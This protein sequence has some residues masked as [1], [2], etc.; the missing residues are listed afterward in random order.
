MYGI[1]NKSGALMVPRRTLLQM[2]AA[3]AAGIWVGHLPP[4]VRGARTGGQSVVVLGGGLSGL[5]AAYEL[6]R[7]GNEVIVLE[8]QQR[9]GGRIYSS[10]EGLLQGQIAEYGATRIPNVHDL[11]L[12]YAHEFGLTLN[13]FPPSRTN[14]LV[15]G[16]AFLQP[17]DGEPWPLNLSPQEQ[18][19]G[20]DY[21]AA[22]LSETSPA[23]RHADALGW[24]PANLA[25]Q[26]DPL[27]MVS[28][29][30]NIGAGRDMINLYMAA[31]GSRSRVC[32]ALIVGAQD[33]LL[34]N[35]TSFAHI[36]GG[37]EN[38]P[39]AIAAALGPAVH[40][41]T[42]VTGIERHAQFM[43][44]YARNESGPLSFQADHVISALPPTILR[45]IPI[46]P[47]LPALCAGDRPV[48]PERGL[49][50]RHPDAEP[51]LERDGHERAQH[52]GD[53]Y[54]RRARLGYQQRPA[55]LVRFAQSLHRRSRVGVRR[56]HG[57]PAQADGRRL[58]RA[59][60][61]SVARP[62][63]SPLLERISLEG[64]ALGARR[65]LGHLA[66][67]GM[68]AQ[69]VAQPGRPAAFRR[70]P[71]HDLGRLDA[72]SDPVGA[73]GRARNRFGGRVRNRGV[74]TSGV[75]TVGI[76]TLSIILGLPL[77]LSLVCRA[78]GCSHQSSVRSAYCCR[79]PFANTE[80]T[81]DHSKRRR[82]VD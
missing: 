33:V 6:S 13:V 54:S 26:F 47:A 38:L 67:T 70:R 73:A 4:P 3:G 77:R 64:A 40:F 10:S 2:A 1:R 62:G 46:R 50:D 32:G 61:A 16:R 57:R 7:C 36:R 75:E 30:R 28:W 66:G 55:R 79:T 27:T 63:R 69:S 60:A 19:L 42:S 34:E 25:R 81:P 11:T 29:L 68:D 8:T 20:P 48:Y 49:E 31:G 65:D 18:L 52:R 15:S 59:G 35:T 22:L 14:Y 43:T 74:R 45:T 23:W 37:N 5:I 17:T 9:V 71:H 80:P 53:Q 72:G 58:S 78:I 44:V 39:R 41:G 51:I 21:P 82:L 12:H 76:V 56:N 24:P